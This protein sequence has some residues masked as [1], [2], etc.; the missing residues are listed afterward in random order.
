[1]FRVAFDCGVA[2]IPHNSKTGCREAFR[3]I[4]SL[5]RNVQ[6][7]CRCVDTQ[8][9]KECTAAV[10]GGESNLD[11]ACCDKLLVWEN[12]HAQSDL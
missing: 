3:P 11:W 5:R 2:G 8:S 10:F 1:M 7:I 4:L 9:V 12:V 6:C